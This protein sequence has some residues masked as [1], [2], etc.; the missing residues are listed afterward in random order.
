MIFRDTH[1][2]VLDGM[3]T[4]TRRLV[5][6]GDFQLDWPMTC[7]FREM[8][9]GGDRLIWRENQTYAVQPG[10][11][12]HAIGRIGII[13]IRREQL[14]EISYE[15]IGAEGITSIGPVPINTAYLMTGA[16]DQNELKQTLFRAE[17]AGLWD[18]LHPKGKRWED[19]P[20]VWVLE[21]DLVR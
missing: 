4:Q 7:V 20:E 17:F 2:E 11:G 13:D 21:F 19:N 5:K 14:Q 18:H 8:K 6:E 3:K 1:E 16:K 12:K 9:S 10:R 15:D